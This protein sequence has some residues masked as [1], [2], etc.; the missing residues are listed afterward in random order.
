MYQFLISVGIDWLLDLDNDKLVRQD[1]HFMD[2]FKSEPSSLYINWAAAMQIQFHTC[3]MEQGFLGTKEQW[4]K[5]YLKH[6]VEQA[7]RRA[8]E[9]INKFVTPFEKYLD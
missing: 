4:A 5:S 2:L 1:V 3:D 7:K 8:N 6:F 9:M